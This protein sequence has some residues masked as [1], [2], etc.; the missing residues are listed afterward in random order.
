MPVLV[1]YLISTISSETSIADADPTLLLVMGIFA[2]A[3]IV[4]FSMNIPEPHAAVAVA[5]GMENSHSPLS[6]RHFVSGVIAIF[7]Y[8]GIEVGISSIVDSFMANS[9]EANGSGA[10]TIITGS[11]ADTY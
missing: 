7:L 8:A 6:F 11:V 5:N 4:L 1:G 3:F 9:I 10:D 2:L